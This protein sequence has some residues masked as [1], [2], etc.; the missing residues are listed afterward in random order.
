[1]PLT[2]YLEHGAALRPEPGQGHASTRA[3]FYSN[4]L[5][6][7]TGQSLDDP[8]GALH[9]DPL[10]AGRY[11][12]D[13]IG[14]RLTSS[15][16]YSLV[17]DNLN[18]R[19]HPTSG[20]RFV[21]SQDFAGLGG[22][23]HYVRT[24]VEGHQYISITKGLVLSLNGDAGY[25]QSLDKSRGAGID[26]V[27]LT[28]RWFDGQ[29]DFAGFDIRG[30]GPRVLRYYYN[31][32]GTLNM[33]RKDATDDALGGR[34]MYRFKAEI[35]LPLGNGA[36]ELGLRPSI[37]AIAGSVFGVTAPPTTDLG[38]GRPVPRHPRCRRQFHLQQ[39]RGPDHRRGHHPD[40]PRRDQESDVRDGLHLGR[41]QRSRLQGSVP[42]QHLEAA[43]VGRFRRQLELA[44]RPV[45][46][47]Y[48]Q[49]PDQI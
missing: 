40:D 28:D 6:D 14:H 8:T 32:D 36:R 43:P 4:Y 7:A 33:N 15:V 1:M 2:E 29:P 12:C 5:S 35:E 38:A 37:F 23:V 49:G 41:H 17:F 19:R 11:L 16:G 25:I 9:C 18:D 10:L 45:P 42:R 13:A 21:F 44:V 27:R 30:I 24:K 3:T 31:S 39:R 22:D 47:R 46:H 20:R 48:R 34:A 26:K